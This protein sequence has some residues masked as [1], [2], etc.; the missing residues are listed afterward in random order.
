MEYAHRPLS[1]RWAIP[2][3]RVDDMMRPDLW[4][5]HSSRQVYLVTAKLT[6]AA[7][8]GP[9]AVLYVQIPDKDCHHGRAGTVFPLWRDKDAT[10]ANADEATVN[11]LSEKHGQRVS[12]EEVWH[13]C[14]GLLGTEAYPERWADPM[15][16][17]LK[18]H[19]PF[20][21]PHEDFK[22]L[23][24]IGLRLVEIAKGIN[25]DKSGVQ[26]TVAVDPSK[27]PDFTDSC[28]HSDDNALRFGGGE[29]TGVT[30][31]IWKHQVSGYR[32]LPRW[33]KTR[34]STPG[35]RKSSPLDDIQPTTWDFTSDLIEVCNK[36]AS[37]NHA[38]DR[39]CP[40]LTRMTAPE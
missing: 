32:T 23:V 39:A 8:D 40:V 5:R 37:L 15:G 7:G 27:L 25:L 36:I 9:T 6:E 31:D 12:G 22:A 30:S 14:A 19:I 3:N 21:D 24:A 34:S 28:Y 13:Y 4:A 2:D 17:T 38:A 33:I 26:C 20:P 1:I 18:P 16:D 29:F 35:G 11:W 10:D